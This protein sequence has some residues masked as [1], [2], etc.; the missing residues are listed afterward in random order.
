MVIL[1]SKYYSTKIESNKEF[2]VYFGEKHHGKLYYENKKLKANFNTL[3]ETNKNLIMERDRLEFKANKQAKILNVLLDF[4][5]S[6]DW[7]TEENTREA[8]IK[9]IEGGIE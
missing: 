1:M 3:I 8:I 9:I 6:D 2:H 4:V 7:N 5:K